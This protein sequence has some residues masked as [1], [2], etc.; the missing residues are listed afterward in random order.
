[1][2]VSAPTPAAATQPA[3][4]PQTLPSDVTSASAPAP[5]PAVAPAPTPL[6]EVMTASA[7]QQ[8]RYSIVNTKQVQLHYDFKDVGP[9]GVSG[10]EV[11]YTRDGKGW[12]K[13]E[14]IQRENPVWVDLE[15][16]TFGLYLLAKTGLGGGREAPIEGDQPH[17]W[18][19]VDLTK[20]VVFLSGVRQSNGTRTLDLTWT[21]RDD[22]FGRKPINLSYSE[23]SNGP[24]SPI[25]PP[26]EN[27]G[28]YTWQIPPSTPPSF[29]VRVEAM[30]LAGNVGQSISPSPIQI[31]LS[32]PSVTN[33]RLSTPAPK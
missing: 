18:V 23:N 31:D 27:T 3:S 1:V 12:Q 4:P 8:P 21:A 33:I 14:G 22:N 17:V 19:Q 29:F 28:A 6:A 20:P 13:F 30:D 2:P 10:V 7:T 26:M 25:A 15:E 24:W 32:Q 11:W 9:S 16:G 5:A